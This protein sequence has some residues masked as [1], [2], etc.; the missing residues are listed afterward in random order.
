MDRIQ[1][2]K[3]LEKLGFRKDAYSIDCRSNESFCLVGGADQWDVFYFE[4]GIE[5]AKKTFAHED[6][7]CAY[8]L[9]LIGK[10]QTAI[11]TRT[12]PRS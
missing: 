6:D 3:E 9:E 4:R 8:F 2:R 5:R 12:P 1:L 7:A 10:D 11:R